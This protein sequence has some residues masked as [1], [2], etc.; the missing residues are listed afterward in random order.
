MKKSNLKLS[1][2]IIIVA[3]GGLVSS[4]NEVAAEPAGMTAGTIEFIKEVPSKTAIINPENGQV[5]IIPNSGSSTKGE[6]RLDHVSNIDFGKNNK[7]IAQS[8]NYYGNFEEVRLASDNSVVTVPSFIQLTDERSLTR[9]WDLK[10]KNDGVFTATDGSNKK[11]N[12]AELYFS[13]L[14]IISSDENALL[15]S[16][17]A[18]TSG[19]IKITTGSNVTLASATNAQGAGTWSIKVGNTAKKTSGLGKDGNESTATGEVDKTKVGRN[20]SVRL[21]VANGTDID[22]ELRYSTD[23]VWELSAAP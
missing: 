10:I 21:N 7:I 11:F 17:P 5:E 13:D 18:A 9:G 19:E 2:G 12:N 1:L 8:Q 15:P 14:A 22:T 3:T 20:P 4:M 23:L 6:L 16:F